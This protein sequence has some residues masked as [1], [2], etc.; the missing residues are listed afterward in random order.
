VRREPGA[1]WTFEVLLEVHD[2]DRSWRYRR[3]A[4]ITAPLAKFGL[5]SAD[6]IPYV[7]PEVA[8]LYKAKGHDI[9]KNA[10]DFDATVP[11]LDSEA[12]TWLSSALEIAH[13]EHPWLAAL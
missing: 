12:R 4:R 9:S 13:P 7:A 2:S 11:R 10:A 1:A 8:L 6:G 5:R 3:D